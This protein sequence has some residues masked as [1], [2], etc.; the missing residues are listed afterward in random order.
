M[1]L[2]ICIYIGLAFA[3]IGLIPNIA[4]C[5]L[6]TLDDAAM[7]YVY[8]EGF[9]EFSFGSV[10][11][12]LTEA[13]AHFNINT[14]Q[15]TEIASLKLG[16]H[17]EYDYKDPLPNPYGWDEDWEN[18]QIGG[19]YTNPTQD[20]HTKGLYFKAVFENIDDPA[21]RVLKSISFG[22]DDVT[23]KIRADFISYSGT[24]DDSHDNTPEYNGHAMNLGVK[25]ITAG[26]GLVGPPDGDASEFNISLSIDGFD[27]GYWVNFT[28]AT[29]TP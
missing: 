10:G 26:D 12:G 11:T 29:V 21:N 22:A 13:T 25:T 17:D 15:F 20:F 8:A 23:G 14:Y 6:K 1:K 2:R 27:K 7:S 19:S 18:I 9:A 28:E 4:Q 24:I 3:F 16:Y 5:E